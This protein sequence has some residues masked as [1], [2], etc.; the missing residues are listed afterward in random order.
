MNE[1]TRHPIL[2]VPKSEAVED[3]YKRQIHIVFILMV[4]VF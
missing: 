4:I 2:D 3:V 1:I